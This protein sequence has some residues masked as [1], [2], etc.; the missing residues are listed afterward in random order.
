MVFRPNPRRPSPRVNLDEQDEHLD[1]QP[2]VYSPECQTWLA[3]G[4]PDSEN[5]AIRRA[6]NLEIPIGAPDFIER[7]E[8]TYNRRLQP[9][10]AGRRPNS[11]T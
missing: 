11:P 7:L 9:K 1:I 10:T 5:A 8:A 6:T 2:F 3:E 4:Q